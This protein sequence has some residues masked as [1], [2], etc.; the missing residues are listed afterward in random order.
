MGR[1]RCFQACLQRHFGIDDQG[2]IFGNNYMLFANGRL[3]SFT[4]PGGGEIFGVSE[5]GQRVLGVTGPGDDEFFVGSIAP[6]PEPGTVWLFIIGAAALGFCSLSSS[7]RRT[8]G[9]NQGI[10]T[11]PA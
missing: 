5:N 10:T 8:Q 3:S 2:D 1:W 7:L 4:V 6:T 9:T 11:I